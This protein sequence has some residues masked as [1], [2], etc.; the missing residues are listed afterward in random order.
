MTA[1]CCWL[2]PDDGWCYLLRPDDDCLL[3]AE[4]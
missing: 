4:S 2:N 3:L 1:A